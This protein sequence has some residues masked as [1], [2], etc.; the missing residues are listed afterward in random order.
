MSISVFKTM[1]VSST[2]SGAKLESLLVN[3][4]SS[5][6]ASSLRVYF[7]CQQ[8]MKAFS[9]PNRGRK[10]MVQRSGVRCE[11][12]QSDA[13]LEGEKIDPSKASALSALEKLKTSAADS[14]FIFNFRK[15]FSLSF[16]CFGRISCYS[17]LGLIVNCYLMNALLNVI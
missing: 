13:A 12:V 7:P 3:S 16:T 2:F 15:F 4:C 10:G 6:S 17:V 9:K 11:V 14:T 8:Q 5:S 1:A